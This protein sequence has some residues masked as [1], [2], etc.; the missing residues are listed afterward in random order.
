MPDFSSAVAWVTRVNSLFFSRVT[1][2]ATVPA[3]PGYTATPAA[4][5]TSMALGPQL[6]VKTAWTPLEITKEAV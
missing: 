4:L 2:W 5:N 6:P 3:C 1:A